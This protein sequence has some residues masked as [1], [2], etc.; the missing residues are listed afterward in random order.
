MYPDRVSAI[1]T[2]CADESVSCVPSEPMVGF[3][4][5]QSPVSFG[6][7]RSSAPVSLNA[8]RSM[9]AVPSTISCPERPSRSATDGPVRNWRSL[10]GWGKFGR[11]CPPP[12]TLQAAR[13]SWPAGW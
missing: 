4:I 13:K 11:S 6:Q 7:P 10:T 1:T 12:L 5:V 2:L 9:L 8:F 3:V